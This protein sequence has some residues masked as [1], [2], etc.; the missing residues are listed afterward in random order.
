[1][2]EWV[3]GCVGEWLGECICWSF[4]SSLRL[5]EIKPRQRPHCEAYG[6]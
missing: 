2:N 4:V 6:L 1:M 3:N 5:R